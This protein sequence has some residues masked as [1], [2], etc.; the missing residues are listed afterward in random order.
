M[1][2]IIED[3]AVI[4]ESMSRHLSAA[5][6]DPVVVGRGEL[7]LARLE[8]RADEGVRRTDRGVALEADRRGHA[9]T[10]RVGRAFGRV[11]RP[12][13]HG[14]PP[15][16]GNGGRARSVARGVTRGAPD[17]SADAQQGRAEC[18]DRPVGTH[19]ATGVTPDGTRGSGWNVT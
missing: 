2:L 3:D 16:P 6:F 17:G 1:V 19:R 4:A 14:E 9:V 8:A 10:A 12:V 13:F 11:S 18:A 5:G 7:G 15:R